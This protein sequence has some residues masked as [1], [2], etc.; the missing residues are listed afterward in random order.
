MLKLVI[1]VENDWLEVFDDG[2]FAVRTSNIEDVIGAVSNGRVVK[3]DSLAERACIR[4]EHPDEDWDYR[5]DV[6]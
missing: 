1:D 5:D 4:V 6:R 2:T 3:E